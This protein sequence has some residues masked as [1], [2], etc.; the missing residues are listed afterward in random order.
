MTRTQK[1]WEWFTEIIKETEEADKKG[2]VENH[3]FIT[4]FF[5]KFDL[6]TT[7]L[8]SMINIQSIKYP[9]FDHETPIISIV[10]L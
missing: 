7:M 10:H 1:Q 2:L 4:Q 8:V 3:I 9:L 6:R 5:D